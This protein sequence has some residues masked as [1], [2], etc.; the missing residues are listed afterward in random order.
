MGGGLLPPRPGPP[1]T[2]MKKR[3]PELA[4]PLMQHQFSDNS[5]ETLQAKRAMLLLQEGNEEAAAMVE[6][7]QLKVPEKNTATAT[8][9]AANI[10]VTPLN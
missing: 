9:M 4:M 10:A 8:T 2:K 5:P 6:Q 1:S 7:H 3:Q